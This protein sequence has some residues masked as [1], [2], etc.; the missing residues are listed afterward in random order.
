MV[1]VEGVTILDQLLLL[2][3]GHSIV[4]GL[5][6]HVLIQSDISPVHDQV[7]E[8][9]L[10]VRLSHL[11]QAKWSDLPVLQCEHLHRDHVE[12]PSL[13]FKANEHVDQVFSEVKLLPGGRDD[14]D[15]VGD[16]LLVQ[17]LF[18][19]FH[20]SALLF[21]ILLQLVHLPFQTFELSL[22]V[23]ALLLD[24][25]LHVLIDLRELSTLISVVDSIGLER[26]RLLLQ[27]LN[28]LFDALLNLTLN[29]G[30]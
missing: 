30:Q 1:H 19:L 18:L 29:L 6:L 10:G 17:C 16:L 21:E 9:N 7:R 27:L 3:S 23:L 14:F 15:C 26:V 28:C 24:V 2:L 20:S 4:L 25:A 11:L 5:S 12:I 22:D 8:R 13:D